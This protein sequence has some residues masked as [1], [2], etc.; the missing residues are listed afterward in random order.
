M[1]DRTLLGLCVV[2]SLFVHMWLVDQNWDPDPVPGGDM[3]IVPLDFDVAV[4]SS[5]SALVMEQTVEETADAEGSEEAARRLLR[6]ATDQYI[7]SVLKAIERRKFQTDAGDQSDLIGNALYTIRI[8]PDD[9]FTDVR[10]VR[11]SGNERLDIAAKRAILAAS[12]VVERPKL[13][14]KRTF[15]LR[16]PVKYQYSL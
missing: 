15:R 12:G 14:G 16:V 11:S 9:T 6:E 7:K 4:V 3:I 13:I 8:L 10:L 2:L 1:T 5:G